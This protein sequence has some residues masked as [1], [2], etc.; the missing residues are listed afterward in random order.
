[1]PFAGRLGL[2]VAAAAL[3]PLGTGDDYL[4][5]VGINTLLYALLA[6]GLNVVVGWAGLLDLGYIAFYGFGAYCYAFLSSSHFGAHWPTLPA[7]GA[8]VVATAGL[9]LLLGLPSR[10]LFGDYLAIVTLFF[11][12]IFQTLVT[13]ADRITLPWNGGPTDITGGPNGI[14]GL[15]NMSFFGLHVTTPRGYFYVG[16]VAF[17]LVA[18]ALH[19]VDGSR[20]GRAWRALREDAVA[21]ELIGT[22][23]NRLRLLAFSF[24]AAVAGL[25]GTIFAA[26]QGATFPANFDLAVLVTVYAMVILGG[27][28][29]LW[30]VVF[31]AVTVNVVLEMLRTAGPARMLFYGVTLAALAAFLRP[32]WWSPVVVGGTIAFGFAVHAIVTA[33]WPGGMSSHHGFTGHWVVLL[34]SP[35]HTGNVAYGALLAS[36]LL[37]TLLRRPAR[38]LALIPVLYLAAFVWENRL[39]VEPSITR[40]ILLGSLMIALMAARPQGLLG[41][42]RSELG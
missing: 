8:I 19:L 11:A 14:V 15:D 20:T 22:P 26:L 24:G 39:V 2:L 33:A 38:F 37:L 25:T 18:G 16:L 35:E 42:A 4:L 31:G 41:Q 30:G 5:R 27:A 7:M 10:R 6:L 23:V 28:G 12:E 9:G 13:N 40:L 29:S 21:A 34:K 17:V 3:F 36:V 1:M 32:R